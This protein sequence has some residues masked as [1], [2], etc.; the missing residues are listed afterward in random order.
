MPLAQSTWEQPRACAAPEERPR[1]WGCDLQHQL[2]GP[3]LAAAWLGGVSGPPRYRPA[4]ARTRPA[5]PP[6]C[7]CDEQILP[8]VYAWVGASFNATPTQLGAITLGRAM[9]QALSSPLG[10]VAGTLLA[11][12]LPTACLA[13]AA[14]S[15]FIPDASEQPC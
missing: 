13:L 14:A 3:I 12:L 5:C 7:R 9:M 6:A 11:Q 10:G 8:A 4:C 2:L 15:P 1:A